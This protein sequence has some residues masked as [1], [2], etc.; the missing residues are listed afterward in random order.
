MKKSQ[1][2]Y[3]VKASGYPLI[4]GGFL[5]IMGKLFKTRPHRLTVRTPGFHP[6]NRSSILREVT[7]KLFR[8]KEFH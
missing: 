7:M 3:R 5:V 6:G 1:S 4:Y 8:S 2:L